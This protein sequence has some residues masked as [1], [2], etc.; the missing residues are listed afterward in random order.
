MGQLPTNGTGEGGDHDVILSTDISDFY[1]R[2][3][4]HRL[5]NAL[6]DATQNTEVV[7]RILFILAK[8][9]PGEVSFGLPVGGHAARVLA[10]A[11][12]NRTDRLLQTGHQ[13]LSLR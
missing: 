6:N 5:E 7:R 12:L 13:L 8:L 4:H 11:V 9:T 2:I 10:E 1:P 3:Y